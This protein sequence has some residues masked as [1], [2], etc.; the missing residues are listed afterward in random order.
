VEKGTGLSEA[1]T[2]YEFL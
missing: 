1:S 2:R